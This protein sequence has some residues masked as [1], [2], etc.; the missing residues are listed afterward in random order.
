V[1]KREKLEKALLFAVLFAMLAFVSVGC[2]SGVTALGEAWNP[3]APLARGGGG[4]GSAAPEEEWNMT[5]GGTGSDKA[6]SVQQIADGGYILAGYAW[7]YGAG[8]YDFWLVKTDYNGIEQWNT[9]FGGTK[10]DGARAVQP[11]ADGG[12]ILAG[13]TY[14]YGAGWKDFWLVKTDSNGNEQWN[15]TFG[16]ADDDFAESVQQTADGGYVL[17][18]CT[19]S[20][21]AGEEDFWLIKVKGEEPT[22]SI[23]DTEPSENPTQA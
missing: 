6:N 3:E 20:Y 21:G 13:H 22:I 17:A 1:K 16:G 7:S 2:A 9:T 18:G 12:Y 11:T 8:G 4:G 19:E 10:W 15:M 14:S 5:F 23:F